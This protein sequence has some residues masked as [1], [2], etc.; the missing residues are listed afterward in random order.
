MKAPAQQEA[1]AL[2]QVQYDGSLNWKRARGELGAGA[3]VVHNTCEMDVGRKRNQSN[4]WIADL[5]AWAEGGVHGHCRQD[6][7]SMRCLLR[8]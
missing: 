7:L 4:A 2:V 8:K 5:G 6:M 3:G 1:A